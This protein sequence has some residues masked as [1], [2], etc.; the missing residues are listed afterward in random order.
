MNLSDL[1]NIDPNNLGSAPLIFRV[2]LIALAVAA[3][4]GAGFWY[5]TD[6][7]INN[8]N[9]VEKEEEV[10]KKEFKD[11]Y[12]KA[13]NL[14]VYEQQ[15]ADLK[16]SFN[17]MLRQLPRKAEVDALLADISQTGVA[18][19]LEFELFK[20]GAPSSQDGFQFMPIQ[21]VVTGTYHQFGQFVSGVAA[22]SRIVTLHNV[23][24]KG[25]SDKKGK[26]RMDSVAR[27][28]HYSDEGT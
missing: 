7:R 18:A 12:Q 21:I 1:N 4:L 15:L 11:L 2:I 8:W 9:K 25:I 22:L 17:N 26:L 13:A 24:L 20:P 19:G 3:I 10:K 27:I 23:T 14:P 16:K 28:Y 6:E 5:D